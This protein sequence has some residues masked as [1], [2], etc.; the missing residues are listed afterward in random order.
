MFA[1]NL[2]RNQHRRDIANMTGD[3]LNRRIEECHG[4]LRHVIATVYTPAC[5]KQ[6]EADQA[7]KPWW[8]FWPSR[9][10]REAKHHLLAA[11]DVALDARWLYDTAIMELNCRK[12]EMN[13]RRPDHPPV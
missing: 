7:P 4:Y 8:R 2:D 6:I 12:I 3:A 11:A 1:A 10:S 13:R 9:E 5:L